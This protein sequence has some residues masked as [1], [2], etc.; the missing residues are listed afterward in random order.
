MREGAERVTRH[1]AMV[2]ELERDN[3]P[4]AATFAREVLETMHCSWGGG[5]VLP[6]ATL[7]G[8][9]PA[10]GMICESAEISSTYLGFPLT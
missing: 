9:L 1:E 5:S 6:G 8:P 3:H 7:A 2:A 4:D 10:S